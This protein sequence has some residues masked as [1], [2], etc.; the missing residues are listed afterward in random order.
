MWGKS[1]ITKEKQWLMSYLSF[2][3]GFILAQDNSLNVW[4]INEWM[5]KWMDGWM[6]GWVNEIKICPEVKE[7]YIINVNNGLPAPY[8]YDI[9][10]NYFIWQYITP[11]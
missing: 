9:P 5:I 10:K 7:S 2:A 11:L 3:L 1:K 6:N 4:L 8:V